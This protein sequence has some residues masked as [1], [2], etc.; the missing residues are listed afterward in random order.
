VHLLVEADGHIG[1]RRGIQGLAIR[2]AKGINRVL[3]RHGR[4]WADR[5]H[6][7]TLTTPREVRHALV[8]VLQNWRKHLSRVCGLD[9]RSSAP[10]FTGWRVATTA[11]PERAPI[12]TPRTWLASVGWRRH[13]LLRFDERP[14]PRL[15]R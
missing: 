15:L 9:P 2:I 12:V 4:I 11:P 8:Y 14:R 13:G 1:L 10:W 5:F 7:R 3:C 6:S